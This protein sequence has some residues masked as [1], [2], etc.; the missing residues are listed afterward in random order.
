MA[1][2]GDEMIAL[3]VEIDT[4]SALTTWSVDPIALIA[5]PIAALLYYRGLRSLGNRRR[6]HSSWRPW[7]FY[8]GL[9]SIALGLLSPIDHFSDELFWVHMTQH[10]L[11]VMVGAPLVLLGAPMIP[12]LRG[13]PRELRRQLV[14]PIAKSL[15]V[16]A[17][18]RTVTRPLVAWPLYTFIIIGW[19]FSAFFEAAL[20]NEA[21]HN[22]EHV[23]FA[24]GA[25]VFW[26]NIIDPHPLRSNLSYLARIPYIFLSVVPAFTLG[27]FLT[28]AASAWYAPYEITAPLHGLSA[29]E[30][31]Q[32][33]GVIMWI[34]GS[35]I[36][37][38]ALMIDL[39]L[40]VRTE[41]DAQNA[42]EANE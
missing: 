41:Q 39:F 23:L 32:L 42:R 29:L 19:H 16:R 25:Y 2:P 38:S 9:F 33:G 26:W 8:L 27:A 18:L 35:F 10:M 12:M 13:V 1:G 20:E 17:F 37:G 7:S 24:L 31:Q 21:L 34:P 3:H 36:I 14:I 11:I 5:I 30:D 22:L 6:F 28:F 40:A 15:P 4:G